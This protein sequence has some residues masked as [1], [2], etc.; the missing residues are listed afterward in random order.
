MQDFGLKPHGNS[1]SHRAIDQI[2][3]RFDCYLWERIRW[4]YFMYGHS[5]AELAS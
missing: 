5:A 2:C 1:H 4:L 3:R